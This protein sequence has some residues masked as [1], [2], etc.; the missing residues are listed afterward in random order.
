M[1]SWKRSFDP[2]SAPKKVA[3]NYLA[4]PAAAVDLLSERAEKDA[5]QAQD[6]ESLSHSE[7]RLARSLAAWFQGKWVRAYT[8]VDIAYLSNPRDTRAADLKQ[9]IYAQATIF[10]R[11][12][13]RP[14]L[15]VCMIVRNNEATL[16]RALKSI[17]PVADE[18]VIVDTGSTDNTLEIA[19]R[20]TE[21]IHHFTWIDNF[22]AAR[23]EALKF[24]TKDWVLSID[25]DE[26][27]DANSVPVVRACLH[28]DSCIYAP[29]QPTSGHSQSFSV[30]RLFP[31][32]A[33]AL[34]KFPL[35]EQIYFPDWQ[36]MFVPMTAFVIHAETERDRPAK[37]D[38]N[39]AIIELMKSGS[40]EEQRLALAYETFERYRRDPDHPDTEALLME[41]TKATQDQYSGMARR[42]F[43]LL[44]SVYIR[45]QKWDE[46]RELLD[47][48]DQYRF[49]G[50]WSFHARANL[51]L[52]DNDKAEAVRQAKAGLAFRD[53]EGPV[54]LMRTDLAKIIQAYPQPL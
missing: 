7:N 9:Q 33:D 5:L 37:S 38:R 1:S 12:S 4:S 27:M 30:P 32:R 23:N 31:R 18:I 20:F 45:M 22:A 29:L 51:A 35:H 24:A 50:L 41:A 15:S 34:W 14:T 28:D 40:D 36:P 16:E 26:Y 52:M 48:A 49:G 46:L 39:L 53:F 3:R 6:Y 21:D 10:S 13:P 47:R 17:Q 19:R 8:E 44:A 42:T 11:K 25:S 43:M 2:G 54:T